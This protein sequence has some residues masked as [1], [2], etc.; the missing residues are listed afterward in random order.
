MKYTTKQ[1]LSM[2][3]QQLMNICYG[4]CDG[5][6]FKK[7]VRVIGEDE[8]FCVHDIYKKGFLDKWIKEDL[9]E[10]EGYLID[11]KEVKQRIKK[12]EKF[13]RRLEK[14]MNK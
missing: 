5:C 11:I 1:L 2:T 13:K 6:P 9:D 12:Y 8:G 7:S 10:I 14:E 3:K 4:C